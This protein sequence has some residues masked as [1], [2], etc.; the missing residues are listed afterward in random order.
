MQARILQWQAKA[1]D[2]NNTLQQLEAYKYES[3]VGEAEKRRLAIINDAM[4]T[5]PLRYKHKKWADFQV[6]NDGQQRIKTIMERYAQSFKNRLKDGNNVLFMGNPGT[7]KTLLSLI[8]YHQ[9]IQAGFRCAYEYSL[10]FLRSLQEKKFLS[11]GAFLSSM[12]FYQ[13]M[14]FLIIDEVTE[15]SGKGGSL[16]DWEKELLFKLI[17]MRYQ[18]K[19]CTL[20]ISNRSKEDVR[21]RL[22]ESTHDRLSD[23]GIALVF[24]WKS[25]RYQK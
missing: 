14:D 9:L 10:D 2:R 13:Q 4:S 1:Q 15:G 11:S 18:Q 3:A 25:Y 20:V 17:N 19:C 21:I 23:N 24:N 16:T 8:L 12:H 6:E 22:G 5:I 7:G